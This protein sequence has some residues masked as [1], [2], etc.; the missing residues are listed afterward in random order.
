MQKL[1][2][3]AAIKNFRRALLAWYR[4]NRRDLPWRRTQ[5]PYRIWVSEIM[6][7]QTV[8]AA[9]IPFYERFLAAFPNVA[10]LAAASETEV[11]ARWAGLGYY[12]RAKLLHQGAKVLQGECQGRLPGTAEALIKIPGI[13]PYTAGAIA[14]IAFGEAAPLVDGNVIRVFARLF[15][16][17]GHA[18]SGPLK[19]TVWERAASLLDPKHPGD[20]NQALMELGATVCR[21]VLPSCERCPVADFCGAQ[22]QGKPEAFPESPPETKTAAL[23]RLVLL[24]RKPG[25]VFLV[26]REKSRWFQGMWELPQDFRDGPAADPRPMVALFRKHFGLDVK[27]LNALPDTRH[28]VTHHRITTQA[29]T[30]EVSGRMRLQKPYVFGEFAPLGRLTDYPLPNLDRK[31]LQ[32]ARLLEI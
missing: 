25:E 24:G 21:P 11:L 3:S 16:L 5:D 8:V 12:R 23:H 10:T 7:Q 26:K 13:G 4:K 31:V 28:A 20:F 2:T 19:K 14:S 29:W 6:L 18:K 9:A 17:T 32:A 27:N 15:A 30:G 22:A 1:R